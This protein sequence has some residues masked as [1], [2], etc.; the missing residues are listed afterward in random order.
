LEIL[1]SRD[2]EKREYGFWYRAKILIKRPKWRKLCV[3]FWDGIMWSYGLKKYGIMGFWPKPPPFNKK[4]KKCSF[5]PREK[6]KN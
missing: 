2:L 3:G 1:R 4:T 6:Q 5:L